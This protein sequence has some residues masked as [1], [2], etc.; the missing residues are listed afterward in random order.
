[1]TTIL[2]ADDHPIV[3]HGVRALLEA[4]PDFQVIGEAQ[5]GLQAAEMAMTLKP[6]VVVADLMM[7]DINGIELCHHVSRSTHSIKVIILSMYNNQGYVLQALRA[8]ARGYVLKDSTAEELVRA[9]HQ[10]VSGHL[11][12][13]SPLSEQAIEAYLQKANN[14]EVDPYETLTSREREVLQLVAK[15]HTNAEIAEL[16]FISQRTV[17]V[18]RSNM[19]SKLNLRTQA[20]VL[21]YAIQKGILPPD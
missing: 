7:G 13:G 9:V 6:D 3:R 5:N 16:L 8:G 1:L 20:Q 10:V 19:M 2:I 21:R 12:L 11:Y 15:G 18:H 4:E 14:S 17:E